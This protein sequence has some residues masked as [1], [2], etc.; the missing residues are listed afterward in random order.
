V[1]LREVAHRVDVFF[2]H[3][4]CGFLFGE[5]TPRCLIAR[6]ESFREILRRRRW[7]GAFR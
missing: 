4:N 2:R 6:P 3:R 5:S 7:G 1:L